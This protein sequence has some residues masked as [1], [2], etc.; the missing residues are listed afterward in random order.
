MSAIFEFLFEVLFALSL[1]Q[2]PW[3]SMSSA[4]SASFSCESPVQA[5]WCFADL[6]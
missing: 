1:G 3:S 5:L 6:D 4:L 2:A